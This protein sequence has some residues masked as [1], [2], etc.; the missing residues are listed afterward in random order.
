[1]AR[2]PVVLLA[3]VGAVVAVGAS[4]FA[5]ITAIDRP[6]TVGAPAERVD[7]PGD[8]GTSIVFGGTGSGDV[9]RVKIPIDAGT[10]VNVGATGFTIELWIKGRRADNTATRCATGDSG[11]IDGNIVVDRDVYGAG[12]RGD[13]GLS[14]AN[15][16]VAWGASRGGAGATVCGSTDVL[17]GRWHH[18]AVT[19]TAANGALAVWVDGRLDASTPSSPAT[20]DISYRVG[21]A[22]S[23]PA[24]DPYLVFGAEKHDAGPAYP[25]FTGSIDDV[26]VSTTVRYAAAF[27]APTEPHALD[28]ATAALYRFDEPSG[29][30][31]VDAAGTSDGVMKIGTGGPTRSADTPF[32]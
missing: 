28:G 11:W 5:V 15:G 9:D 29:T 7:P 32:G 12:D 25:S 21:R 14:L 19:R 6:A 1:M 20:G 17:D 13:F 10:G 30:T 22:T 27:D 26:R 4:A 31:V 16:R 18:V 24:S 2:R 8:A 23:W 3:V